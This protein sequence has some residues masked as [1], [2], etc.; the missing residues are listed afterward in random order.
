MRTLGNRGGNGGDGGDGG[1]RGT[2]GKGGGARTQCQ[3]WVMAREAGAMDDL[4][5]QV[6]SCVAQA[7]GI[8]EHGVEG[9]KMAGWTAGTSAS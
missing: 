9:M 2:G 1:D 8:P 5:C 3:V 6:A 7:C 4:Y